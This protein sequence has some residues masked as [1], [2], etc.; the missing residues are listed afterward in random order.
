MQAEDEKRNAIKRDLKENS[1]AFGQCLALAEK[2]AGVLHRI[3]QPPPRREEEVFTEDGV[4]D[5][6]TRIVDEKAKSFHNI[7][8]CDRLRHEQHT[9]IFQRL[10]ERAKAEQAAE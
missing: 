4:L 1:R 5:C 6:P 2:D 10:R 7:W 8:K 3:T 9:E